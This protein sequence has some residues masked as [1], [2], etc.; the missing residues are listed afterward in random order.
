M[1]FGPE[2]HRNTHTQRETIADKRYENEMK[3]KDKNKIQLSVFWSSI[4]PSD[5]ATVHTFLLCQTKVTF[6]SSFFVCFMIHNTGKMGVS[7][8]VCPSVLFDS[9]RPDLI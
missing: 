7:L 2:R 4:N 5:I 8:V 9:F 6:S 3:R 1:H